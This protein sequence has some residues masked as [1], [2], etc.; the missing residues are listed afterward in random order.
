MKDPSL[1]P[2]I[3]ALIGALGLVIVAIVGML[4]LLIST[5]RH[6]KEANQA[7]NC[8]PAGTPKI[9]DEVS[10]IALEVKGLATSQAR[11]QTDLRE[12]RKEQAAVAVALGQHL[13][14]DKG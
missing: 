6:A 3:V 10:T 9:A 4:P 12:V 5:R 1:T 11:I 8:R 13:A 7:V 14:E 2:I